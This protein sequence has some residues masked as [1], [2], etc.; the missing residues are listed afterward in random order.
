MGAIAGIIGVALIAL[1]PPTLALFLPLYLGIRLIRYLE[2]MPLP[3]DFH[4][5]SCPRTRKVKIKSP[6][7]LAGGVALYLSLV[8]WWTQHFARNW[9]MADDGGPPAHFGVFDL[10]GNLLPILVYV[11]IASLFL[12]LFGP[13]T[14]K[15]P[16]CRQKR[17]AEAKPGP[18]FTLKIV[19][20]GSLL[21]MAGFLYWSTTSS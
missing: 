12:L 13:R 3:S 14:W 5:A 21:G 19:V 2:L 16:E 18:W 1:G 11:I 7:M 6:A 8:F 4:S 9:H 20:L 17:S 15:C 10:P